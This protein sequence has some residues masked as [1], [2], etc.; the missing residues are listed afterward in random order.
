M[1]L[2]LAGRERAAP[3]PAD[4]LHASGYEP[5]KRAAFNSYFSD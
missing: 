2:G 3:S 1:F 5:C 4:F